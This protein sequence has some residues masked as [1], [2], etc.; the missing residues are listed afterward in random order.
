MLVNLDICDHPFLYHFFHL[1]RLILTNQ[2]ETT[3]LAS[4]ASCILQLLH[5]S[6]SAQSDSTFHEVRLIAFVLYG[7]IL[8]FCHLMYLMPQKV[9]IFYFKKRQ[10]F[11]CF[12]RLFYISVTRIS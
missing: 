9:F 4:R 8:Y 5:R 2:N 6:L 7:M 1:A 10:L 12:S 11:L 3:W